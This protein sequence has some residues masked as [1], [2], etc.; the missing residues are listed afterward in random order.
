[1]RTLSKRRDLAEAASNFFRCLRELDRQGF[2]LIVAEKLPDEG[3][4]AAINDRLRR[5]ATLDARDT[6]G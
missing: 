3:L 2:D 1:M 6:P 4:G 5:A